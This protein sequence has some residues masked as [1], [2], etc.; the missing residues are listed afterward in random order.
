MYSK[1]KKEVRGNFTKWL[2][3]IYLISSSLRPFAQVKMPPKQMDNIK[4]G[5]SPI[6]VGEFALF[7]ER[8]LSKKLSFEVG[9]GM[10]TDNYIKNFLNEVQQVQARKVVLGPTADFNFRY[11]PRR[12]GGDIYFLWEAKYRLYRKK[13][14]LDGGATV[15]KEYDQVFIPRFGIGYHSYFDDRFF[16]DFSF[17]AGFNFDKNLQYGIVEPVK[18]VKLHFGFNMKV[19]YL[20]NKGRYGK[21]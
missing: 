17:N 11:Y 9:A 20:L 1:M 5:V 12:M 18:L 8:S 19:G 21:K 2:F 4:F 7:Y 13:F 10:L 15:F 14:M 6:F 3:F 16:M